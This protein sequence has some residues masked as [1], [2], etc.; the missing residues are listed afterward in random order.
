MDEAKAV[1]FTNYKRTDGFEISLT[2]RGDSGTEVLNNMDKALESLKEKGA[3][4]VAK[5]F[6]RPQ[7]PTKSCPTHSVD[8]KEK[9]NKQGEKFFSHSRGTYPNLEYCNGQ[10]FPGELRTKV[11]NSFSNTSE[12]VNLDD[13]NF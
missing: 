9:V 6:S 5:S 7:V 10:G 13:I 4:P 1:C 3:T 12:E 2:F 11:D 8:M